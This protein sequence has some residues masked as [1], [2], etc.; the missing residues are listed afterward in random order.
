M[1]FLQ[2]LRL[3]MHTPSHSYTNAQKEAVHDISPMSQPII[4]AAYVI[5]CSQISLR[6]KTNE[7]RD[8][9]L[10]ARRISRPW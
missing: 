2:H 8:A 9:A 6:H 1:H 3:C 7:N 10:Y 4:H 5:T